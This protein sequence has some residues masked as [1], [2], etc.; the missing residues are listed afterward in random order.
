[1]NSI[2][3]MFHKPWLFLIIVILGTGLKFYKLDYSLF[4]Y[5]EVATVLHT[6]SHKS[7]QIPLN[8]IKNIQFY[9]EQF[10]LK[11]QNENIFSQLKGLYSRTNLNPLHYS[12]L[13]VGTEL[14]EMRT[15]ITGYSMFSFSFLYCL[16][17]FFWPKNFSVPL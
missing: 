1:M 11:N 7:F 4:W 10:H 2:Q 15:F 14:S 6:S 5:D 16:F 8:E 17:F 9:E 13:M 12:F 3:K